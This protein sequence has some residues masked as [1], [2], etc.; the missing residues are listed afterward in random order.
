MAQCGCTVSQTTASGCGLTAGDTITFEG[1]PQWHWLVRL[2]AWL[3][4][5]E[6]PPRKAKLRQ[7][8]VVGN[9]TSSYGIAP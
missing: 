5:N 8:V 2:A 7:F 1:I 4:S 6:L 3:T 9:A